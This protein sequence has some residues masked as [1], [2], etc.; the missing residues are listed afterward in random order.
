MRARGGLRG[1]P[2]GSGGGFRL[3]PRVFVSRADLESA[4]LTGFGSRARRKMLFKAGEGRMEELARTLRAEVGGNLVNVRSYRNSEESLSEQFSRA[5]N[6]LSLTGLVVLV[7]G[8]IGV[9]SVTRVFIEQK[10]KSIAVLKCVGA[11]GRQLTAAYLAQVIA[12]G[13]AGSLLGV[14]LAKAA[15]LF[16]HAR[17]AESLPPN[18]GYGLSGG[19]VAQG[20]GMGLLISL[21]FSALP[22]LRIRHIKPSMLLREA[23][24]ALPRRRLDVL[25]WS[26]A[27]GVVAGL[28]V[29][30][31]WQA[32]SL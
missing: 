20:L 7:L 26:V 5:E 13:L 10:K 24:D 16:V 6:Y 23:D 4:G 14:A 31:A 9:S 27:L 22:L 15:L 11:T 29:L 30:A 1:W 8:G 12:L 25:R 18:M 32:G 19:A 28:V 17:F 3:G 2:G 21:L